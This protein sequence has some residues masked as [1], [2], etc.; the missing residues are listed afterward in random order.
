MK[1]RLGK[2]QNWIPIVSGLR[3]AIIFEKTE[4][5]ILPQVGQGWF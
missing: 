2:Q 5:I 3:N 1:V 4:A